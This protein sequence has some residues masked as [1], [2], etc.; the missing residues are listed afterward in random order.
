MLNM[1]DNRP[2]ICEHCRSLTSLAGRSGLAFRL[3]HPGEVVVVAGAMMS[4]PQSKQVLLPHRLC[5][6]QGQQLQRP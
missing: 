1:S 6:Q 5:Q 2:Q 4:Q 3:G